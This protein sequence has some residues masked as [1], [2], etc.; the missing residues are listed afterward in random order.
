VPRAQLLGS[1]AF[2]LVLAAVSSANR[3]GARWSNDSPLPG[4]A[5]LLAALHFVVA[6]SVIARM[7]VTFATLIVPLAGSSR[8]FLTRSE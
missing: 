4:K 7:I 3:P 6:I 2:V 1:I 8:V 5:I